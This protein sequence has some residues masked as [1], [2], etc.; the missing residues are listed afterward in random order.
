MQLAVMYDYS[1][2]SLN[3]TCTCSTLNSLKYLDNTH[4]YPRMMYSYASLTFRIVFSLSRHSSKHNHRECEF[5]RFVNL[6]NLEA[7]FKV[8]TT[9]LKT[10]VKLSLSSDYEEVKCL[11]KLNTNLKI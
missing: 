1:N 8:Y 2:F 7:Y 9:R 4:F 11:I 3:P 10:L 6:L 5:R